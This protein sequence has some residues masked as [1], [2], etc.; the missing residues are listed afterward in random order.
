MQSTPISQA[1]QVTYNLAFNFPRGK[2]SFH[3][4]AANPKVNHDL[5]IRYRLCARGASETDLHFFNEN[6]E[7]LSYEELSALISQKKAKRVYMIGD[8]FV[9]EVY[10]KN[11]KLLFKQLSPDT[12]KEWPPDAIGETTVYA[13]YHK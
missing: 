11:G 3:A 6:K 8:V 13:N 7:P 10:D 1:T 4:F 12:S 9:V 5:G 2:V